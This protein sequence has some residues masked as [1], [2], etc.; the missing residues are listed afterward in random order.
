MHRIPSLKCYKECTYMKCFAIHM[1][2]SPI[3]LSVSWGKITDKGV[4][5]TLNFPLAYPLFHSNFSLPPCLG[6]FL[7]QGITYAR[8]H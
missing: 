7:F 6:N 5:C 2:E 1:H 3:I 4:E 8:T